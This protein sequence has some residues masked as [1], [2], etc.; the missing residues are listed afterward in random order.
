MLLHE[1]SGKYLHNKKEE[2][3]WLY[4]D[5]VDTPRN[6]LTKATKD[7]VDYSRFVCDLSKP[8]YGFNCWMDWF[9]R[10]LKPELLSTFP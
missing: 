7:R 4:E 8:N 6:R 9:T 2:G 10:E 3:G 5:P 1:R